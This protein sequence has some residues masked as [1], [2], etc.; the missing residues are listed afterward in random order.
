[1]AY[2]RNGF[3]EGI[4][5]AAKMVN[6][7][8]GIRDRQDAREWKQKEWDYKV[9]QDKKV[10]DFKDRQQDHIEKHQ[11]ASL[12]ETIRAHRANEGIAA[13]H[14]NLARTKYND[15]L[16]REKEQREAEEMYMAGID[17]GDSGITSVDIDTV[18]FA[19]KGSFT[20]G[21]GNYAA[22]KFGLNAPEGASTNGVFGLLD[23]G[24]GNV[25]IG[26]LDN[27]NGKKRV[28][29]VGDA[30][31]KD[32]A[33]KMLKES[34]ATDEHVNVLMGNYTERK[35]TEA[36]LTTGI[37]YDKLNQLKAQ[38]SERNANANFD[39]LSGG[40]INNGYDALIARE[41]ANID[42]QKQQNLENFNK[43]LK[44]DAD[45][46][47]GVSRSLNQERIAREEARLASELNARNEAR[48]DAL[49]TA[50][51]KASKDVKEKILEEV[52]A[53]N[54]SRGKSLTS[55][56]TGA[57]L[58]KEYKTHKKVEE[59]QSKGL[60]SG[61]E[62]RS[63]TRYSTGVEH[64]DDLAKS[65]DINKFTKSIGDDVGKH[66]D[67]K[68]G[69]RGEAS[70][71]ATKANAF[72]SSTYGGI[73]NKLINSLEHK[74]QVTGL[75]LTMTRLGTKDPATAF[76]F[77]QRD[78]GGSSSVSETE[79]NAAKS[80]FANAREYGAKHG[81]TDREMNTILRV[82]TDKMVKERISIHKFEDV[83]ND[84]VGAK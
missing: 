4:D 46:E 52:E 14:L 22:Q 64:S 20:S 72:V 37:N 68:S 21:L 29:T 71:N 12:N 57:A 63:K 15:A 65:D 67:T 1:M 81:Y 9:D 19:I 40:V 76:Y 48:M 59:A 50:Y 75:T 8:H 44:E 5:A 11:T 27:A 78:G 83:F 6:I 24:K 74:A 84:V 13:G 70:V 17:G 56:L 31:P 26:Y 73:T 54:W 43:K 79:I 34:G 35:P 33:V 2:Q 10:W 55:G 36:D 80:V 23:D 28:H 18:P 32:Q 61:I 30:M 3:L 62:A 47:A 53:I 38:Q 25:V 60:L 45:L 41:Q 69:K 58:V 77:L 49:K 51:P 82:V 39:P 16:R 66:F 7:Y 42:K